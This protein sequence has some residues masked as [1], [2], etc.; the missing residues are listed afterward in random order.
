MQLDNKTFGTMGQKTHLEAHTVSQPKNF[1]LET[2]DKA[3][4]IP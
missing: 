2:K 1:M 3:N 4:K